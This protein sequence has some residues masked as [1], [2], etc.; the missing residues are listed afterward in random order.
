MLRSVTGRVRGIRVGLLSW[1]LCFVAACN[2]YDDSLL[3]GSLGTDPGGASAVSGASGMASMAGH[4][5]GP[6]SAGSNINDDAGAGG[7]AADAGS[8]GA[9]SVAGGPGE[10]GGAPATGGAGGSSGAPTAGSSGGPTAE[11][12]DDFEDQ[13]GFILPLHKRNGPWYVF[14]DKTAGK[15]SP[16]TIALLTG[17][18]ARPGSTAGLHLTA[19]GFTDWGA[20]VGADLVNLAAKK[21]AYDVS[22]YRGIRFYAKVASGT[23]SSLKLL[24]TTTFSDPDGGKCNDA[25][26]DKR[27]SDHLFYPVSS[28]KSTWDVYECDFDELVQQGFG[29]VQPELDPTSVYSIQFTLSTKLLPVDLWIDDVSFI[30]K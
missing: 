5:E 10:P 16:F 28:I 24:V 3:M 27:C 30:L 11:L 20:G 17:E 19:S 15:L 18:G 13:D 21:V 7:A 8:A 2:T 14:S 12:I 29:L 6:G 25:V 4:A 1:A 22:A 26:A 9:D 23:Q